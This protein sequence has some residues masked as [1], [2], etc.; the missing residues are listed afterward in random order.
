[1]SDER[2]PDHRGVLGSCLTLPLTTVWKSLLCRFPMQVPEGWIRGSPGLLDFT[3]CFY[4]LFQ[5]GFLL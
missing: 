3:D 1:M 4:Y 5:G 2:F